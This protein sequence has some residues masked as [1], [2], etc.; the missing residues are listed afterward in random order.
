MIQG[1]QK[2]ETS[3][4]RQRYSRSGRLLHRNE[5]RLYRKKNIW[6]CSYIHY[7]I[8][9]VRRKIEVINPHMP[10]RGTMVYKPSYACIDFREQSPP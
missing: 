6:T 4:H 1:P 3:I 8:F 5:L 2:D 9:K 7:S 10:H